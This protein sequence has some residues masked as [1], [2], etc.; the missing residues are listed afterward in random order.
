MMSKESQLQSAE[1]TVADLEQQ[2]ELLKGSVKVDSREAERHPTIMKGLGDYAEV[3]Q[4]IAGDYAFITKF[5]KVARIEHKT[6][7]GLIKDIGTRRV[8]DQL[9]RQDKDISIILAEGW[10]TTTHSGM[11]RTQSKEYKHRPYV[12][13]WNYLM[14]AQLAGVYIYLSPNEFMTSKIILAIFDYLNKEEHTALSQRQRLISMNPGLTP[15]QVTL[16]SIPAV[17]AGLAE[18][19]DEHFKSSLQSL[20]NA[21]ISE[22]EEVEG[23]GQKKAQ[24]IY[25]YVRNLI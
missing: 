12:W 21:E 6:W 24:M 5:Q 17:G 14:S 23:I 18:K 22:L 1:N 20:C 15:K 10:I 2:I 19:L 9:R 25:K 7:D 4:L 3:R 13:L 11:V 16:S 8:T